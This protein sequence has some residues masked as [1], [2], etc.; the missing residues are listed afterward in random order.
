MSHKN[1]HHRSGDLEI[2][3]AT[4]TQ[5]QVLHHRSGDL[6]TSSAAKSL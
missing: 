6:E 3:L 5:W 4:K 2:T 1:L